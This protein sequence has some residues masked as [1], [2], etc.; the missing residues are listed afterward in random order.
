MKFHEQIPMLLNVGH[1]GEVYE[2][3]DDLEVLNNM[4][5]EFVNLRGIYY[6]VGVPNNIEK[7]KFELEF[8]FI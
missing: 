5:D 6:E 8:A 1:E 7:L 2:H 3:D 4:Q